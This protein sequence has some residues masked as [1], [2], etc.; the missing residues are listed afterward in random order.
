MLPVATA[1]IGACCALL[2]QGPTRRMGLTT[3]GSSLLAVLTRWQL[4]RLFSEK[5]R[6]QIEAIDGDFEVRQYAPRVHAVTVLN[7][8]PWKQSLKEGFDRLAKYI[9][10]ANSRGIEIDMTAPVM[11]T[12][13]TTDRAT[14]SV[15]FGMP[16][17]EPFDSLPAPNDRQITLRRIPA[18]RVA[19]LSYSGRYGQEIPSK[20]RQE[21]LTHVR[22]AGLIPIGDV[23][24]AGYDPPWTLPWLR[25]NELQVELSS[26]P[27]LPSNDE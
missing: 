21:L 9:A 17:S 7:A 20:K 25:H 11:V 12:V 16:D 5:A 14:R 24:F 1:G 8:A 2:G 23:I 6:Y 3:L 10:G 13:G 27:G 19:A 18:R 22:A 4:A 26:M 15:A